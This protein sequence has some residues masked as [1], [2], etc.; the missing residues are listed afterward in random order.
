M[1]KILILS[2]LL[3]AVPAFGQGKR[4]WVL[5]SAGEM[6]EY[7]PAT[8]TA[9]SKIKVP[10]DAVS[11]PQNLSVNGLGQILFAPAVSIPLGESDVASPHKIWFWNGQSA[12]TLDLGATRQV[13]VTGSNRAVTESAPSV[14]L[15][16]D[17]THLFWFAN[18][19]RRLLRDEVDLSTA[20]TWQMWQTDLTGNARQ[21]LITLKFPECRCTSGVCEETC[22]YASVWA[23]DDGVGSFVF[24]TQSIASGT[25]TV[26]KQTSRCQQNAGQWNCT[27]LADPVPRVL[28]SISDGTTII[29][30]IPDTGCCGWS[31][32]S[33]DQT[34]VRHLAQPDDPKRIVFDEFDS[35]KNPD[36]DVSFY[37][38]NARLSPS[39]R[40]VAMTVVATSDPNKPIQLSQQGETN[41]EE[42]KALRKALADLPAVEVKSLDDSSHRPVFLPHATLVGWIANDDLLLVEN[43][44]LV[45]YNVMTGARHKSA[46]AAPDASRVFLR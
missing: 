23:P 4:L 14:Y 10:G 13:A 43:H 32:A 3:L 6:V 15:S 1:R 12:L 21:D 9:K 28:D 38:A 2:G 40:S 11:A 33:D 41:P 16:A 42:S 25:G 44:F 5:S 17:G 29:E 31:N 22:P 30:A 18:Q 7:D 46:I 45:I 37:T 27:P 34:I 20:T 36:Y 8:F 39:L 35:Y 26:Y 19:A 24:M